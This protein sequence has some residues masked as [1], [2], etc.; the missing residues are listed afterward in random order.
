MTTLTD[1]DALA[2]DPKP[3]K[4]AGREWLLPADIPIPLMLKVEQLAGEEITDE[5][6]RGLYTDVLELFQVHQPEL[7]ELPISLR[8]LLAAIPVVY[9]GAQPAGAG[10]ADPPRKPKAAGTKSSSR[11][12]ATRSRSSRS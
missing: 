8:Q 9:Y 6:V 3:V 7:S 2:P 1:L 4:L 10:D 11:P 5:L 12:K